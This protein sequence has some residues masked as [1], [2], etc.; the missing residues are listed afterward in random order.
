MTMGQVNTIAVGGSEHSCIIGPV[1]NAIISLDCLMRKHT[2]GLGGNNP[3]VKGE[4][5]GVSFVQ[6]LWPN[7][8][9]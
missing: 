5:G 3:G 8:M 2:S 9:D 4:A 6:R 7:S 1:A